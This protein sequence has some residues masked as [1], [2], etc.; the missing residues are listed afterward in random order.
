M[1]KKAIAVLLA[2]LVLFSFSACDNSPKTPSEAQEK[3][4]SAAADDAVMA[5]ATATKYLFTSDSSSSSTGMAS[6]STTTGDDSFA[7]E[8]GAIL[9]AEANENEYT[10][11]LKAA[12]TA[13]EHKANI[14]LTLRG[15]GSDN[16]ASMIVGGKVEWVP[17]EET[18]DVTWD[19]AFRGDLTIDLTGSSGSYRLALDD[20]HVTL[21]STGTS[22]GM[23][24]SYSAPGYSGE[25]VGLE[26]NYGL[27]VDLSDENVGLECEKA[28][29]YKGDKYVLTEAIEAA[30]TASVVRAVITVAVAP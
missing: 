27:D 3:E 21:A 24:I 9:E 23:K 15:E 30:I 17:N 16:A 25:L 19:G 8:F 5:A 11:Q 1:T 20:F 13:R 29:W 22:V 10:T 6:R 7:A 12:M 14:N 28:I 18:T 2:L 26:V 4:I